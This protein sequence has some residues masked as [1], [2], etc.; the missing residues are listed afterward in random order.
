MTFYGL[1]IFTF[2]LSVIKWKFNYDVGGIW[3]KIIVEGGK[4]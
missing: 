4:Y 2:I 1:G 3:S